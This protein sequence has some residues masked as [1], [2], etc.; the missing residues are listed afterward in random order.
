[1]AKTQKE[2]G[3]D[4]E[5]VQNEEILPNWAPPSS[6]KCETR[7]DTFM[8]GNIEQHKYKLPI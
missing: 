8:T 2:S 7:A 5:K 6:L 1:M 3:G 4:E